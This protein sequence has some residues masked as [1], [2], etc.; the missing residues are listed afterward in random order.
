MLNRPQ[1]S[2]LVKAL[3]A[4]EQY[5]QEGEPLVQL[6][7]VRAALKALWAVCPERGEPALEHLDAGHTDAA[8]RAV[9]GGPSVHQ[10]GKSGKRSSSK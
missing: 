10:V 1:E 8:I 3:V 5:A 2:L 9:R 4:L 6:T 7:R